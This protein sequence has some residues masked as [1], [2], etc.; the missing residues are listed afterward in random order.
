MKYGSPHCKIQLDLA[1]RGTIE[2]LAPVAEGD[3]GR[4]KRPV[5]VQIVVTG[6]G[7]RD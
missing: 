6:S 3:S 1:K 4:P 5:D 7:N 2:K